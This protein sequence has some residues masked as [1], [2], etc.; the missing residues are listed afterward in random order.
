MQV[1]RTEMSVI[2]R[3]GVPNDADAL[4]Q[5]AARTFI[6]TFT[7]NTH[8]DDMKV[9]V[10]EAYGPAQQG[11]ELVDPNIATLWAE[12]ETQLPEYAQ[13]RRKPAPACVTGE[14]PIELWRF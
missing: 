2:I 5:L 14:Q 10:A 9:Y 7:A 3:S 1:K 13:L 12:I 6:D 11:R 8:P 4:A